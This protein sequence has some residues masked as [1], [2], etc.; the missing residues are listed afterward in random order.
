MKRRNFLTVGSSSLVCL[1]GCVGTLTSSDDEQC[2]SVPATSSGE[3][4]RELDSET[5]IQ[6]RCVKA[7]AV[8][9]EMIL[10]QMENLSSSA[11]ALAVALDGRKVFDRGYG[12]RDAATHREPEMETTP[13]TLF[14]IASLAKPMTQAAIVSLVAETDI[15]HETPVFER[16]GL[17]PLDEVADDRIFDITVKQCLDH[18]LGWDRNESGDPLFEQSTIRRQHD[19]AR[20]PTTE[21]I[22]RAWMDIPLDFEPGTKR[23]YSNLGYTLLELLIESETD[24]KYIEYLHDHVLGPSG[25]DRQH[26]QEARRSRDDRPEREVDYEGWGRYSGFNIEPMTGTAGLVSTASAYLRFLTDYDLRTGKERPADLGTLNLFRISSGY[27][28]GSLSTC[29]F[30]FPNG[31]DAVGFFNNDNHNRHDVWSLMRETIGSIDSETWREA[32]SQVE[33]PDSV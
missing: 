4:D 1:A 9:D 24:I 16:L 11:A 32:R 27:F 31:V 17:E 15:D 13:D 33:P 25:I 18:R 6:G 14:R 21:E 19:L 5:P 29:A 3:E 10:E 26:V 30:Q 12:Y 2:S 7:L 23:A 8:L 22:V 20:S 28:D